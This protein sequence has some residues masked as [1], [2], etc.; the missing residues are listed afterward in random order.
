MISHSVEL[1][2]TKVCFLHIQLIGTNVWLPKTHMFH[3]KKILSPQDLLQNRSL[4]TLQ[5]LNRRRRLFRSSLC[6][7]VGEL[8]FGFNIFDFDLSVQVGS[9]TKPIKRNSVGSGYVSHCWT[10]AL[11]DHLDHRF[12]ILQNNIALAPECIVVNVL[13]TILRSGGNLCVHGRGSILTLLERHSRTTPL[14]PCKRWPVLLLGAFLL[15]VA[16]SAVR[17]GVWA[18]LSFKCCPRPL[19]RPSVWPVLPSMGRHFLCLAVQERVLSA[20]GTMARSQHSTTFSAHQIPA[21]RWAP[22]PKNFLGRLVVL[23]GPRALPRYWNSPTWMF[24]PRMALPVPP[25]ETASRL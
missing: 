1:C 16:P 4:E 15:W 25:P 2:D 23:L 14:H 5:I 8:V 22:A 11:D 19:E 17:V 18:A 20:M 13:L 9:A 10:S 6:Q 21:V 3:P 7:L 24:H 12:I